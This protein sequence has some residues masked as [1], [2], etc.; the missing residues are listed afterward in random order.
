VTSPVL[1]MIRARR[2]QLMGVLASGFPCVPGLWGTGL[3]RFHGAAGQ[4]SDHDAC[5]R[6][7]A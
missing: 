6:L 3:C 7:R 2:Y 5:W 1:A 4:G